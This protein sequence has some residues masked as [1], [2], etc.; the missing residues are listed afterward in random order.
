ML[1]VVNTVQS[2]SILLQLLTQLHPILALQE[3]YSCIIEQLTER[4]QPYPVVSQVGWYALQRASVLLEFKASEQILGVQIPVA[5]ILPEAITL[6]GPSVAV[7][8]A[9]Y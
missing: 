7:N 8:L 6:Q 1:A 5:E 2:V 4:A 3:F 9:H